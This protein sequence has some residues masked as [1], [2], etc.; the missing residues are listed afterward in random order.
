MQPLRAVKAGASSP[1]GDSQQAK[2]AFTAVVDDSDFDSASAPVEVEKSGLDSLLEEADSFA[3]K[4]DRT[5]KKGKIASIEDELKGLSLEDDKDQGFMQFARLKTTPDVSVEG[6]LG[7][8]LQETKEFFAN[9]TPQQIWFAGVT[10][11]IFFGMILTGVVVFLMGG[12]HLRG[13]E[14]EVQ[15]RRATLLK[16]KGTQW[17]MLLT[18]K[19]KRFAE[20]EDLRAISGEGFQKILA[21]SRAKVAQETET[22]KMLP[23]SNVAPDAFATG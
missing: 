16:N 2:K 21:E 14:A 7:K 8:W 20:I 13:D 23:P 1:S 9:P 4:K 12:M 19:K 6:R 22:Q 17:A 3:L 5:R 15:A 10:A 18:E 11:F